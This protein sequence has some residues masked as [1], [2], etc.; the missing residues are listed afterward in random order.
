MAKDVETDSDR[1][2]KLEDDSMEV[3][4]LSRQIKDVKMAEKNKPELYAKAIAKLS[5]EYETVKDLA[6]LKRVAKAKLE[7]ASVDD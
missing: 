4:S 6:S 5:D 2:E 1:E 3:D 7:K